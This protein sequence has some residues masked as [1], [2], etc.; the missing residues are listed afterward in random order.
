LSKPTT[1]RQWILR[2]SKGALALGGL[3]VLG[4]QALASKADSSKEKIYHWKM[5][6][7]WPPQFPG[8][9]TG[10]EKLAQNI[11]TLSG[12]RIKIKVYGAGELVPAMGVFDAVSRGVAELGHGASYYWQGKHPACTFFASVPFGLTADEMNGWI[13]YGGAQQLWDEVYAPFHVK[14]FAAG[15]TG[16]QMGGWFNK[17]IKKVED[18]KGLKMRMPGL[19]GEVLTKLGATVVTLAGGEI[20]QALKT[21]SIDATEWV[22]PYNDQA[23]GLHK[24]AQYYYWPGWHEPGTTLECIINKKLFESLPSDLQKVIEISCQAANLDMQ[25]EFTARNAQALANLVVE[26]RVKIRKFP[27]EVLKEIDKISQEV[28]LEYSK[29]DK[30]TGKVYKHFMNYRK[31]CMAWIKVAEQGY[32][33]ARSLRDRTGDVK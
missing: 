5:V 26:H 6:T 2:A 13:Y 27:E 25:S 17:E 30:L 29:K 24:A 1:R 23:F 31:A 32:S 22:G 18:F 8:L 20:F 15:N 7:T 4:S 28:L 3:G 12:G 14:G 19:G 11:E 10:A 21:G 9:G 33:L 16:V